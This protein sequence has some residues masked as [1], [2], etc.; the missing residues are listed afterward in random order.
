MRSLQLPPRSSRA[1]S[2]PVQSRSPAV[3]DHLSQSTCPLKPNPDVV[4]L[5]FEVKEAARSARI[6][7]TGW[8]AA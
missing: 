2:K 1:T 4:S 6:E 7:N 3:M 5:D 8:S